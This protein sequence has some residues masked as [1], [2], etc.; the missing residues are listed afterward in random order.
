[1]LVEEQTQQETDMARC[2]REVQAQMTTM[3]QHIESLL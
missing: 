1:M 3:Q 2:E